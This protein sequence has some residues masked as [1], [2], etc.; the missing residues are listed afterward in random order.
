MPASS[1]TWSEI[2]SFYVTVW[3]QVQKVEKK[4]LHVR[5][6]GA[7]PLNWLMIALSAM[8]WL[9]IT[10]L[11]YPSLIIVQNELARFLLLFLWQWFRLSRSKTFITWINLSLTFSAYR[12]NCKHKSFLSII[13]R[14]RTKSTGP[15]PNCFYLNPWLLQFR[16]CFALGCFT[17]K[18]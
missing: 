8:F 14:L 10:T 12:T 17:S 2:W 6:E 4:L 5:A 13:Q 16:N 11:N 3:K 15:N 9:Y 1:T 7:E 18:R